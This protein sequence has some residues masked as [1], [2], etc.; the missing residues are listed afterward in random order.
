M[1]DFEDLCAKVGAKILDEQVLHEGSIVTV[2][3]NLFG[4]L[5][6]FRLS[7]GLSGWMGPAITFPALQFLL[8][9]TWTVYVIFLPK[10]AAEVG[11][12]KDIVPWLLLLDQAIFA[13]M[14][15]RLGMAAD[16]IAKAMGRLGKWMALVTAVSCAAFLLLPFAAMT[17]SPWLL[18]ALTVVWSATSSALRAPPLVLLSR[19]TAA[20]EQPWAAGLSFFGLGVAGAIAPFLTAALRDIDARLPFAI[21]SLTLVAHHARHRLRRAAPACRAPAE[22]TP[23]PA[24]GV[25]VAFLAAI[26]LL[27]LG[28]QLHFAVNS[29]PNCLHF[30]KPEELERL[31]PAFWIGFDLR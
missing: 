28:F 31:M 7:A 26:V 15:W 30:A 3:P 16:R 29:A 25:P 11:L 4:S 8:A 23:A 27:G 6:V 5:G 17:G 24:S 19:Y 20:P 21:C 14:D 1:K 12:A 9:L 10:L 22:K 18:I 13:V 2:M